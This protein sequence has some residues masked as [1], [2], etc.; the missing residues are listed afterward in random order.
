[1]NMLKKLI[2]SIFIVFLFPNFENEELVYSVEIEGLSIITGSIGKC[3]LKFNKINENEYQMNII[4]KTTKLAKIIYP[5]FDSIKLSLDNNLSLLKLNHLTK[6]NKKREISS[7]IN[8]IDKTIIS[9]GKKLDFYNDTLFSPYSLIYFL[10][11]KNIALNDRYNYKVLDGEKIKNILLKV[12][13]IEKIKVP[14]GTFECLNIT[15]VNDKNLIKNNGVLEIWYTNDDNK[16]HIKIKLN[17]KIGTF[18]MKLNK[19]IENE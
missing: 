3:N 18:I 7:E 1:M 9:N 10:R 5:Y 16:I 14:Y 4:T 2:L 15:P 6:S 19:I 17:T 12:A 11:K 13:K 8:K